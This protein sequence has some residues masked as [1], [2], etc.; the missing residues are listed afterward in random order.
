MLKRRCRYLK[1]SVIEVR[2]KLFYFHEDREWTEKA[3][4][5]RQ[6]FIPSFIDYINNSRS[7]DSRM[8]ELPHNNISSTICYYAAKLFNSL[9]KERLSNTWKTNS[10]NFTISFL[11]TLLLGH[12]YF[13]ATYFICHCMF[14]LAC[15]SFLLLCHFTLFHYV[16]SF[17]TCILDISCIF[18]YFCHLSLSGRTCEGS[19]R[20]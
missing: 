14:I 16:T 17:W 7:K 15:P 20:H 18:I 13:I 5:W 11:S 4:W 10:S 8:V 6:H 12:H 19:L 3:T 2:H 9:T 1:N